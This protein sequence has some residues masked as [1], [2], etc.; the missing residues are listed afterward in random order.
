MHLK[1]RL[2]L[3]HTLHAPEVTTEVA[4]HI[5]P[6]GAS[7]VASHIV[8]TIQQ[9]MFAVNIMVSWFVDYSKINFIQMLA[10][11]EVPSNFGNLTMT[12]TEQ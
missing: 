5:A 2:K 11:M 12:Y 6:E 1:L 4:P 8:I 9:Y 3:H 10:L 7:E